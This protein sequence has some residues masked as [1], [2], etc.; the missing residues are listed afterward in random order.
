MSHTPTP[1]Q[2][3]RYRRFFCQDCDIDE[4]NQDGWVSEISIDRPDGPNKYVQ[5]A[6]ISQQYPCT[7]ANAEL[8]VRAVNAHEDLLEACKRCLAVLTL[9]M[10]DEIGSTSLHRLLRAAIAKAETDK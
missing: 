4:G 5:I 8:I 10:G 6:V 3:G 2:I 1:W 9:G 7:E